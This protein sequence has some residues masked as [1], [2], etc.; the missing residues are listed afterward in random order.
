MV[1]DEAAVANGNAAEG[2]PKFL[3]GAAR[4]V[5]APKGARAGTLKPTGQEAGVSQTKV[6]G[7]EL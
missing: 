2:N 5:L 7:S 1:F 4:L 3:S 6:K